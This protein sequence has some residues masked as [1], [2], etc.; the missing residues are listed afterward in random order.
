MK[1]SLNEIKK[2][3]DIKISTDELVKLIGSRLVEVEGTEDL[4]PKYKNIYIVKIS[5]AHTAYS[6]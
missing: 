3:V 4:S 5:P 1:I 6:Q 2:Y